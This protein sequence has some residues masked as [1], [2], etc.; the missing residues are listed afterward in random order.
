LISEFLSNYS[1]WAHSVIAQTTPRVQDRG[2]EFY[3]VIEPK[4][5]FIDIVNSLNK[6]VL[7]AIKLPSSFYKLVKNEKKQ[8]YGWRIVSTLTRSEVREGIQQ[9]YNENPGI[10]LHFEESYLVN[11]NFE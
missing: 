9:F 4:L 2:K 11:E 1:I 8:M 10:I 3:C 5:A 7:D 6:L